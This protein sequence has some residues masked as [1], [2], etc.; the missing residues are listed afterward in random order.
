MQPPNWDQP[1]RCHIDASALAV[2]GTLIQLDDDGYDRAVAYFSKRLNQAEEN[3]RTNDRE[4]LGLIY[5]LKQF[6]CYLEGTEFE[7]ITNNQVLKN[8][9]S[10]LISAGVKLVGSAFCLNSESQN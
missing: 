5:F 1:F 9:F 10:N 7:V 2:G 6:R 8:F 4:L 3:Y